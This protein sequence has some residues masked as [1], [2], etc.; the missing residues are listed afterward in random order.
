MK[1]PWLPVRFRSRP[2]GLLGFLGRLLGTVFKHYLKQM[3]HVYVYV[4][5]EPA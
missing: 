1:L 2:Q 5:L 4:I 3:E